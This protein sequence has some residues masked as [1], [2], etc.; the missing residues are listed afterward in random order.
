GPITYGL[1]TWVT[2]GNH[3]LAILATGLFFV[4]GLV[5]LRRVEFPPTV[6]AH[7]PGTGR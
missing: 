1:V 4:M 7:H 3:R 5:L 2:S 6:V